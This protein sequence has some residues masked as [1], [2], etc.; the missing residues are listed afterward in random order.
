MIGIIGNTQGVKSEIAP[1]VKAS[2]MND[3]IE[4]LE[5]AGALDVAVLDAEVLEFVE[6]VR[7]LFSTPLKLIFK[8]F[9]GKQYLSLHS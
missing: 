1:K 4:S 2:Q 3:Q 6:D 9:G 8:V 5:A 7:L